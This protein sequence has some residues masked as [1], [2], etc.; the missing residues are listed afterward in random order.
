MFYRERR[1]PRG[2]DQLSH[3]NANQDRRIFRVQEVEFCI[4][5]V[6]DRRAEAMLTKIES[7]LLWLY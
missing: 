5:K 1:T 3:P 4:D 6:L 7:S 2:R